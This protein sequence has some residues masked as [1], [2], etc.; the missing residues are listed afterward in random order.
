MKKIQS[1]RSLF[2]LIALLALIFTACNRGGN[3][4]VAT[5]LPPGTHAVTV[6]DVIQ[7]SKYTYL[8]VFEN[9]DKYWMAV[10]KQ[11]AKAGDVYYYSSSMEMKDFHSKELDRTFPSIY[12]VQD[13]SSTL[14]SPDN[15]GRPTGKVPPQRIA[16]IAVDPAPDGISIAELYKNQEN[17]AEKK[18]K[19]RGAV[20]KF[21]ANIMGKNWVHI[22]DGTEYKGNFDLTITTKDVVEEGNVVTFEGII[23]LNKDFGAGYSYDVIMEEAEASDIK[24]DVGQPM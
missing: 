19:V 6:I 12:F 4:Q 21:N 3:K 2:S 7:T 10:N 18:V 22:Q 16:A 15:P 23:M 24:A 8:Q 20:V 11:E 9:N 14:T 1:T 5:D 17:Y 13:L